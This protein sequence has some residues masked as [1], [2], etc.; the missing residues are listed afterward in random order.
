[1]TDGEAFDTLNALDVAIEAVRGIPTHGP[2]AAY[3]IAR[4]KVIA[5]AIR[6]DWYLSE[7][8]RTERASS[9]AEVEELRAYKRDHEPTDWLARAEAANPAVSSE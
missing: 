2:D 3:L 7:R 6:V 1:M 8:D 9:A 5:A 4:L